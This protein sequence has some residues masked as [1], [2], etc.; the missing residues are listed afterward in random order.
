MGPSGDFGR[1][2]QNRPPR[3]PSGQ[4]FGALLPRFGSLL[5]PSCGVPKPLLWFLGPSW[6]AGT[7]SWSLFG[8]SLG[9]RGSILEASWAVLRRVEAQWANV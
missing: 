6:I 8:G 7:P 2:G 5:G 1:F 3:G 4:P 9:W